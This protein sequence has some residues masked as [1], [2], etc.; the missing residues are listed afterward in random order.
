MVAI[1]GFR[2]VLFGFLFVF[3]FALG[4]CD[5]FFILC[6][7][8]IY[9]VVDRWGGVVAGTHQT[10]HGSFTGSDGGRR[11]GMEVEK[12]EDDR[13]EVDDRGKGGS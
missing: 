4:F 9:I 13:K 7:L 1:I 5:G 10:V 8:A 12:K 2:L 3:L 6:F 11:A